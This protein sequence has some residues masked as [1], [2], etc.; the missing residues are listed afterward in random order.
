M[1]VCSTCNN[2]TALVSDILMVII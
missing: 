2:E 1:H